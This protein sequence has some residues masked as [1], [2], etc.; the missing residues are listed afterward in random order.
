MAVVTRDAINVN[1]PVVVVVPFT[2]AANPKRIYPSH[3]WMPKGSA[4]LRMDSIAKCEQIR[5]IAV[6]RLIS[7]RGKLTSS[8][9]AELEQAIRIT[10]ALR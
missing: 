2:D 9:V 5:A 7:F 6:S 4:G 10:L 8:Q 3:V 1:C